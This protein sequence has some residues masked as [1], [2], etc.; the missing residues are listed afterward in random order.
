MSPD[1]PTASSGMTRIQLLI[2]IALTLLIVALSLP[3]WLE[4][5]KVLQANSD[6]N[7][8]AAAIQKYAKH[9]G[10]YPQKL[11]DLVTNPGVAGW[12]GDY[13]ESIPKNPWGGSYQMLR[14]AYKVCIPADQPHVPEKY[15]LGGIAEISS[16]YLEGEAGEKYWW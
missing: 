3:P 6:V 14:D 8:I 5:R 10:A 15:K 2:L 7:R 9:T 12:K 1:N 4:Y 11:E 13:L 16:V